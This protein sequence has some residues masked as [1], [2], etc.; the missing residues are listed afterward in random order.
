MKRIFTVFALV[1]LLLLTGAGYG[2]AA[3][4]IL[5]PKGLV[6]RYDDGSLVGTAIHLRGGASV[7]IHL[8]VK[9]FYSKSSIDAFDWYDVDQVVRYGLTTPASNSAVM[10][11]ESNFSNSSEYQGEIGDTLDDSYRRLSTYRIT[12]AEL[13]SGTTTTTLSWNS[14]IELVSLGENVTYRTP[15]VNLQITISPGVYDDGGGTCNAAGIGFM[16]LL[17]PLVFIRKR[18][19]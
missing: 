10:I 4:Y 17:L 6:L 3:R 8:E 15:N 7:T 2:E 13:A 12:A 1:G 16:A 18:K 5:H 14:S 9:D 11:N 19:L